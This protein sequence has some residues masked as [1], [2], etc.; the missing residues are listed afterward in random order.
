MDGDLMFASWT[1]GL[2]LIA[3]TIAFHAGGV[4]SMALVMVG[5]VSGWR[6]GTLVYVM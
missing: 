1:W 3:L 2:S 5:S 6:T 4:V